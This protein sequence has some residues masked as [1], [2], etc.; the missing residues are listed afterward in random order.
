MIWKKFFGQGQASKRE[1]AERAGDVYRDSLHS[2]RK[3]PS[4]YHTWTMPAGFETEG[5][6]VA[7]FIQSTPNHQLRATLRKLP[8]EN[9]VFDDLDCVL[10]KNGWALRVV[11]AF[12]SQLA[13]YNWRLKNEPNP[14]R[15]SDLPADE[16]KEIVI[17]RL[18]DTLLKHTNAGHD[19]TPSLET[20][21]R[22]Q[23]GRNL[24]A[25]GYPQDARPVFEICKRQSY[26]SPAQREL[27]TFWDYF[28]LYSTAFIS[29]KSCDISAALEASA[30]VTR[31]G[32]DETVFRGT[33]DW[34][35]KNH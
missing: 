31:L 12:A 10:E 14:G 1:P 26:Q 35:K 4:N 5:V 33:V 6:S 19:V 30:K 32:I 7:D 8:I 28:C 22:E 27:M 24:V 29:R 16:F 23:L 21:L 20:F 9:L 17:S 11:M 18:I 13:I 25:G 2:F 3:V 34:L 15:R